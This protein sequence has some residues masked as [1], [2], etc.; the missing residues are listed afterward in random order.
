[1]GEL[2]T[3]GVALVDLLDKNPE[4]ITSAYAMHAARVVKSFWSLSDRIMEKFA[5]GWLDNGPAIGYPDWWLKKVGFQYGPPPPPPNHPP[6][7]ESNDCSDVA[8][9][10]CLD[11]C[12]T[13]LA[14]CAHRCVKHC[15]TSSK[16]NS[17]DLTEA[18]FT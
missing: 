17:K 12:N 10:N 16:L 14:D 3:E 7:Q 13:N 6:I 5:D 11:Q 18:F 15:P 1:M 8:V 9:H 4:H 2:E